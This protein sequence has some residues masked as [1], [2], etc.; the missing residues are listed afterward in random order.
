MREHVSR[1]RSRHKR[2][3]LQYITKHARTQNLAVAE[4][5]PRTSC[6]NVPRRTLAAPL[7]FSIHKATELF[8]QT[9]K[10]GSSIATCNKSTWC[11]D[12]ITPVMKEY[13]LGTLDSLEKCNKF[14][15]MFRKG[16]RKI[17]KCFRVL[18]VLE[19]CSKFKWSRLFTLRRGWGEMVV[20]CVSWRSEQRNVIVYSFYAGWASTIFP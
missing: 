20:S 17:W 2:Q 10:I 4:L 14:T 12:Y 7:I 13:A 16:V 8:I 15:W 3:W 18:R 6:Q 9:Q 1:G 19:A 11:S 5:H